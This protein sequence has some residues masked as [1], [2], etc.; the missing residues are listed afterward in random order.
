MKVYFVQPQP[1][2]GKLLPE[3]LVGNC[4][5]TLGGKLDS[6]Q[7]AGFN[8]WDRLGKDRAGNDKRTLS[9]TLPTSGL[10]RAKVFSPMETVDPE[11]NVTI[12]A[13]GKAQ[14]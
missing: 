1:Y 11:G 7:V 12:H 3:G 9:V 6:V 5:V 8:V 10:F 4:K 2:G 13:R 14:I